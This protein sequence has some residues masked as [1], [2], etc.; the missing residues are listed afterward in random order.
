MVKV[1]KSV[2]DCLSSVDVSS[3]TGLTGVLRWGITS[4][5]KSSSDMDE[6]FCRS[7]DMYS[8]SAYNLSSNPVF[9]QE[10]LCTVIYWHK[11]H[12]KAEALM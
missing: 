7:W 4:T 5:G 9:V 12:K 6:Q 11:V 3:P 8:D 2:F 10:H 1:A